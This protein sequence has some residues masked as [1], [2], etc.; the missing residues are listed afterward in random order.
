MEQ[1]LKYIYTVYEKGSFSKAARA[2]YLTQPALSIAVQKAEEKIGMPLFDRSQKPLTLTPAG[3]IDIEKIRQ[4]RQLEDELHRKVEDL[5]KLNTGHIR[6]GATSFF[7]SYILPPILLDYHRQYPDVTLEI[8]ETDSYELKEMLKDRKLDLTF[9]SRPLDESFYKN[10]FAFQDPILL[11]VPSVFAINEKLSGYALTAH[12]ILRRRH[13]TDNCSSICL[14]RFNDVPF[15]LLKSRYDLRKRTDSLFAEA[16]ITPDIFMEASQ[17]STLYALAEAGLGATFISD[18]IIQ[19]P[20]E[21]VLFYKIS[22]PLAVR[23][24]NIVTNKNCYISHAANLFIELMMQ[25]Y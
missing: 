8:I 19:K 6:I 10:H 3:E 20:D 11:A 24:M 7:L 5:A 21:R 16:G 13:L 15:V 2:L 14:D 17:M 22:S 18:R 12:D 23:E 9:V 1:E 4:I 25:Y